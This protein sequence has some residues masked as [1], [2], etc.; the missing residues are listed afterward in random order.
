MFDAMGVDTSLA[1]EEEM[2][3]ANPAQSGWTALPYEARV[4]SMGQIATIIT[5]TLLP[6]QFL[7]EMSRAAG[8]EN[9]TLGEAV[10]LAEQRMEGTTE[11]VGVEDTTE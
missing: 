6:I 9:P 4:S 5:Q 7:L 8:N 3:N 1:D 10:A 11:Q 2:K